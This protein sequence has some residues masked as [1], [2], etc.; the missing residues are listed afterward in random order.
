MNPVQP[1]CRESYAENLDDEME[2]NIFQAFHAC[3]LTSPAYLSKTKVTWPKGRPCKKP[4]EERAA[5][6]PPIVGSLGSETY[7]QP[8]RMCGNGTHLAESTRPCS[9]RWSLT[10][11]SLSQQHKCRSTICIRRL[12]AHHDAQSSAK[13]HQTWPHEIHDSCANSGAVACSRNVCPSTHICCAWVFVHTGLGRVWVL[14]IFIG[15]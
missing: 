7:R 13:S 10:E 5:L 6:G 3:A 1:H 11:Q 14:R 9:P 15:Q 4:A 8:R 12:P 2:E